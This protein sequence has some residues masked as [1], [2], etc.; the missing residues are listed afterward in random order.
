[1][2]SLSQMQFGSVE[3]AADDRE[4]ISRFAV[5]EVMTCGMTSGL[6]AHLPAVQ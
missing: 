5:W 4:Q 3:R 6:L 2:A 1:M